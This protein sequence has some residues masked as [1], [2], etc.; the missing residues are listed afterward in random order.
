M[1]AGRGTA[2]RVAASQGSRPAPTSGRRQAFGRTWWGRAWVDALEQRARLDPNR[3]PRG[4]T[5]ARSGAVGELRVMVGEARAPVQGRRIRPYTVRLRVRT[6]D[7][8]EWAR[9]LD[10]VAA[11]LGHTAA[12]LDGELPPQVADDIAGSGLDLLPGAGEVGPS[13]TCPD[14]ANPC[15]HAAAVCYLVADAL[16]AD[17][18]VLLLLR[19]RTREEVLAGLRSR[20]R[21]AATPAESPPRHVTTRG[22][23]PPAVDH[24]EGVDA[25][26]VLGAL[27]PA[28]PIPTPPMPPEQPGHPAALPV[29]P[30]PGSTT[31]STGSNKARG[32]VGGKVGGPAGDATVRDDLFTL[33]AD[34]AVRAWELA[35][36]IGSGGLDLD[37]ESDL[38]RRADRALG[39]SAFPTLV[40]RSGVA[41]REL[42]RWGLAWRYGGATALELLRETWQP[43]TGGADADALKAAKVAL[44]TAS[45]QSVRVHRNRITAGGVQLRFGRDGLWYPYARSDGG[46]DPAG[47]PQPDPTRAAAVL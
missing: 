17:P 34:A 10:A 43:D 37:P 28:G 29:E 30:P 14:S 38:A 2:T 20:R 8:D 46:W 16:D 36:G 25:R 39:T 42:A 5:Y 47:P 45:G 1:S 23:G 27:P 44:R 35:V 18:F 19:G 15:K 22:S 13:C 21:G 4:R 7:D 41:D 11:Q 40:A 3:L 33:A 12:L 9:L 6:F 24:D 32:P 26:T 31:G